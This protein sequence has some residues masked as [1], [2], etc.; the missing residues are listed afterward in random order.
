MNPEDKILIRKSDKRDLKEILEIFK[1]ARKF[2]RENNN[3]SQWT[4]EYPGESHILDDIN[5][6]HSFV[7]E[8]ANKEIIMTFAFIIGEDSTYRIIKDGKW[9]ND[10]PYGT[11]HRIASNGREKGVMKEACDFCFLFVNNIRIDTHE[12]NI[13]ML[14]VLKK[15]GFSRCG[16]INCRDGSPRIAFQKNKISF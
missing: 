16:I 8:N 13:P 2:M 6:G 9:L 1:T 3:Y 4:D 10:E 12:D 11:I 14:N 7:G 15:L 5:N